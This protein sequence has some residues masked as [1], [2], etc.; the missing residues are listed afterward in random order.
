MTWL[1]STMPGVAER[2]V[3]Y[4][5]RPTGHEI[6]RGTVSGVYSGTYHGEP[7]GKA[8]MSI[9]PVRRELEAH[10]KLVR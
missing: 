2:L 4:Q 7:I 1:I 10:A 9:Y 8:S 5:G 6:L 3:D